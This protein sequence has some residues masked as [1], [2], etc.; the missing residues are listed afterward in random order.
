[1]EIT[2][3]EKRFLDVFRKLS[4]EKSRDDIFFAATS[5]VRAQEALRRDYGLPDQPPKAAGGA[6]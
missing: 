5:M 3:K 1:M 6:A 2:N 4:N